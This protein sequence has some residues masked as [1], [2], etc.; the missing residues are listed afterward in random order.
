MKI[1]KYV[2][3]FLIIFIPISI[4]AQEKNSIEKKFEMKTY[5]LVFLKKGT[6]RNQDSITVNKLQEQHIAHLDKMTMDGK[7]DVC[8]PL[9]EDGD[10]RGIC[11]Y[12]VATAEEAEKL[13]ND[14]PMVKSGRLKVEIHPFYSAKG[15]TL[16]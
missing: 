3:S 9:L 10:I 11:I 13:A 12:N 1:S 4:L 7:M 5:Y 16:K 15:A 14:D 2:I 6:N 8:G